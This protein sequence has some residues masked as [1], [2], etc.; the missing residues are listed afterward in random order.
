[1][2]INKNI[3]KKYLKKK[4]PSRWKKFF[5]L[6]GFIIF[7]GASIWILFFS[8]LTQIKNEEIYSS[9]DKLEKESLG[10]MVENYLGGKY[11]FI[12]PKDNIVSFSKRGLNQYFT[13]KERLIREITI[14]KKFPGKLIINFDCRDNY[15]IWCESE[16]C[17]FVDE[18]G[19]IFSAL[20]NSDLEKYKDEVL[21][22]KSSGFNQLQIGDFLFDQKKAKF[23]ATLLG[24]I[25]G[26]FSFSFKSQAIMPVL[27]ANEIELETENGWKILLNL[28]EDFD[29]Q[30]K[31]IEKILSEK[32]KEE[33]LENLE[34]I[35]LRISGKAVYKMKNIEIKEEEKKEEDDS[36][37]KENEEKNQ[38]EE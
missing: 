30:I 18:E 20:S 29:K 11:L 9:C 13:E 22:I 3:N 38:E 7:I 6:F 5:L 26:K 1:M 24:K 4:K 2:K 28:E 27:A 33:N 15:F 19:N 37:D 21:K 12:F 35:D 25:D 31:I 23:L 14:E 8:K 10:K 36:L 17:F 32:L 16:G 34:Y